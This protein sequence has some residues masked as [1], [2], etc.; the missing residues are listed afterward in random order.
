MCSLPSARS[1]APMRPSLILSLAAA[2]ATTAAALAASPPARAADGVYGGTTRDRHPIVLK[3]DR[4]GQALRSVIISWTATCPDG[5]FSDASELTPA[6]PQPGFAPDQDEL[7]VDRNAKARFVG[8]QIETFNSDTTSA[9]V[10]VKLAGKLTATKA[11]G[12]ISA[13]VTIL[14]NATGNV[15][16]ACR[17]AETAWEAFRSPGILYGGSTSQSEPVVLRL[18]RQ[19]RRVDDVITVW[20][21]KCA[22]DGVLRIPDHFV[23]FPIKSTG[24]FGNPFSDDVP[25]GDGAKAHVDYD[26]AGR[27]TKTAA[28]GRL[29]VKFASADAAGTPGLACDTGAVSW[30]AKSG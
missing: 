16:A 21:A 23:R 15:V 5:P 25:I 12:T 24:A 27:V 17:L 19:R 13:D 6:K 1:V 30:S 4:D 26:V 2:A 28:K 22:P 29:H 11:S 8:T 3:T 14:D 10:V 7:V 9:G 20:D 18:N